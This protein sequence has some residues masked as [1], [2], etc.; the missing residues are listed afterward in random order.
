M[1]C[2]NVNGEEIKEQKAGHK[3]SK[4]TWKKWPKAIQH[5]V[6]CHSGHSEQT[7]DVIQYVSDEVTPV[8]CCA[9]VIAGKRHFQAQLCSNPVLFF[10]GWTPSFKQLYAALL[11]HCLVKTLVL[12]AGYVWN[13]VCFCPRHWCK[14]MSGRCWDC[15]W[16]AHTLLA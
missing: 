3:L 11:Q 4:S 5:A 14:V 1:S 13:F 8:L 15:T 10:V 2:E 6:S 12:P 9:E 7:G 16:V